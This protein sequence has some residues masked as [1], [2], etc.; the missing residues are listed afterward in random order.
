MWKKGPED[1]GEQVKGFLEE[2]K[3][4]LDE[5]DVLV[6]KISQQSKEVAEYFLMD[7]DKFKVEDLFT[8]IIKFVKGV[9]EAKKVRTNLSVVNVSTCR[10]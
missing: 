1:L 8:E 9:S 10:G 3:G 5:L 4:K 6:E 7:D 2:T